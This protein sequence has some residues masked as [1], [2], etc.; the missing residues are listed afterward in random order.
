MPRPSRSHW[1]AAPLD[2]DRAFERVAAGRGDRFEQAGRH[3]L[4]RFADVGEH[5][6][7]GAV[8]RLR[9]AA[10]EAAVAEERRLL[11]ARDPRDRQRDAE[12]LRLADDL[13]RA[14]RAAAAAPG[15]RRTGRAARR[16][17][18]A[19]RGRAA[20]SAT[21]SSGRWRGRG[22]R[23]ASRRATSRRCRTRA[24]RAGRRCVR[25]ATRASSPR[26]TDRARGPCARADQLGGQLAAALGR[27]AGPA[28][29]SRA[30]PACPWRA[31]PEERRLALV[32]DPDRAQLRRADAGVRDRGLRGADDAGPDLL[33][34]VL[35]PAR[36]REVLGELAI[37]AAANAQL[38]VDDEARRARRSLVDREDHVRGVS[39]SGR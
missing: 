33:R 20:S 6:A 10:L 5:E 35:D 8:G 38:V 28:R 32:R 9:L 23:S 4:A 27:C 2:E 36:A 1:I 39:A 11:V 31:F 14:A 17:S 25:A 21:R 12:Q 7:A 3:G 15:R 18:R 34:V 13:G 19:S 22:R 37:A 26:S 29:R 16:P 24:R 30:R